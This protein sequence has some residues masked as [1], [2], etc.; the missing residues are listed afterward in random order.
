M[1]CLAF[2]LYNFS[3]KDENNTNSTYISSANLRSWA[4]SQY[5]T[6][7]KPHPTGFLEDIS[8]IEEVTIDHRA[9]FFSGGIS[10]IGKF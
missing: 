10:L 9:L 4:I 8:E 6:F 1:L 5:W 3:S 7:Q 2:F